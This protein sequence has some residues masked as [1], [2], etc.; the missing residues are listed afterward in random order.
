MHTVIYSPDGEMFEVAASRMRSL[1]NEGWTLTFPE[2][3]S[4]VF[5]AEP[6]TVARKP[7]ARKIKP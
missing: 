1:L 4:K 7:R 6:V 5:S 2:D 3:L